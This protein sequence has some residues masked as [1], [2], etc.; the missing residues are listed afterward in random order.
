MEKSIINDEE[1]RE[2]DY[3]MLF[4]EDATS[5]E[6]FKKIEISFFCFL[7]HLCEKYKWNIT[8]IKTEINDIAVIAYILNFNIDNI[9]SIYLNSMVITDDDNTDSYPQTLN[10]IE[11]IPENKYTND[12]LDYKIVIEQIQKLH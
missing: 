9:D 11:Y 6:H 2:L 3:F 1:W 8:A 7:N 10:A 12:K 5:P 4:F